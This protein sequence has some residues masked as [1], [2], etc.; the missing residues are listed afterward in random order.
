G[1]GSGSPTQARTAADRDPAAACALLREAHGL[2][3]GPVLADL[4]EGAAL[5]LDA[6]VAQA[7]RAIRSAREAGASAD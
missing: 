2:W 3:R 5:P 1:V 4:A 6:V 7:R